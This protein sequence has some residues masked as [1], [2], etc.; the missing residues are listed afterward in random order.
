[1]SRFWVHRSGKSGLENLVKLSLAVGIG[2]VYN[3]NNNN[4]NRA[5]THFCTGFLLIVFTYIFNFHCTYI[6]GTTTFVLSLENPMSPL[7][8]HYVSKTTPF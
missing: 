4:N 6:M 2:L 1:M 5:Y 7:D 8:I 3:N